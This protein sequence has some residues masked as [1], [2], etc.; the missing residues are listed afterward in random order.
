MPQY[1]CAANKSHTQYFGLAMDKPPQCCGRP[2]MLAQDAQQSA[3]AAKPQTVSPY[4]RSAPQQSQTGQK[5]W[6][7]FW[8]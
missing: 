6:W 2:M 4:E 7:Q 3:A 5:K 8:K 1:V